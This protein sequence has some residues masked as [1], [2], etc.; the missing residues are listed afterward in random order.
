MTRK[1]IQDRKSP[2]ISGPGPA[3][4]IGIAL[5]LCAAWMLVWRGSLDGVFH[6]D[7]YGNIV[8]NLRIR[9]LWPLDD[10]LQNNRPIGLYS[11]AVNYHFSG[12][13]PYAY[14]VTNL[15]IHLV[16]GLLLYT[17]C[18]LTGR[19]LNGTVSRTDGAA[20]TAAD[21]T[22][23]RAAASALDN[24]Q[25]RLIL[26]SGLIASLWVVHPLTTQAVTNIVQ[27]YESLSSLGYLGA[28]VGLLIYL[29][30]F[31]WRGCSLI[32]PAAWIGLMSKEVFATAP[33]VILLF[34]RLISQQKW[35]S[36]AKLR[37]LPYMLMV[38]PY[39]WFV[40][41]VA[42]FFDPV[43]T[44]GSS[45]G[46][47]MESISSWEY[48]RTQPE[49]LWHYLGLVVWPKDLCFDYLWRIQG[50]PWIYRPLGASII[51]MLL[52]G[53]ASY[54]RGLRSAVSST[55][56]ILPVGLSSIGMAG[57]LVLTFFLILSPTS[58]VMP[59]ADIAVE[60]RMYLASSVVVAGI[61]LGA[62]AIA[63]GLLRQSERPLVLKAGLACIVLFCFAM[64]SWR[65]HLRNQD[66]RDGL[67]LWRTAAR[68]SPENP[69]AWYNIGRELFNKGDRNAA[70]RPMISAVGLS[71]KRVPFFDLGLA[72]CLRHIKR[73]DDAI[74]LYK[75][76]ISSQPRYPE[77]YNN[78]G[79]VYLDLGQLDQAEEAFQTAVEMD[80]PEARY[81]LALV[82]LKQHRPTEA[83]RL[84]EQTLV[85]HPEFAVAARRLAWLL[86]TSEQE[87]LR[88]VA[89]AKR[90]LDEH[91]DLGKTQSA[92][93][94]DT[95]GVIRAAFGDFSGAIQ[96]TNKAVEIARRRAEPDTSYI[97]DLQQRLATYELGKP[98]V[99][100]L[101]P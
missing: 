98:W 69:R 61:V 32:L 43:R 30:G 48:L 58:S 12:E 7:D 33:L 73:Y 59:I 78:L 76:A 100:G 66:Y 86:A 64:L 5:I 54:V 1:E 52:L 53:L 101:Q 29:R 60:H 41:S 38:S 94:F 10:F 87:E 88:D 28:W 75:Y 40:P 84:L 51:F 6:F 34:D 22:A 80:H 90:L 35:F 55:D 36:I 74:T 27:R 70:L 95:E 63:G 50:N 56:G 24:G 25:L 68:I 8:D 57:W 89:T 72:D 23:A 83:I 46:L 49:V 96:S 17:G 14:H 15:F 93:V 71:P 92:A 19:I 31:R 11:F 18:Y 99:G 91:Y 67:V 82:C 9:R 47:G 45:M 20:A 85:Q 21:S 39:V 42:R 26:V 44:Q 13:T 4:V 97:T 65:T 79:A 16:N 77:A 3:L 37:W 62:T 2:S 81:N